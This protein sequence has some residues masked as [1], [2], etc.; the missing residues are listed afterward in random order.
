MPPSLLYLNPF[1]KVQLP[2]GNRVNVDRLDA[3][4]FVLFEPLLGQPI[5]VWLFFESP[6]KGN[7]VIVIAL[8]TIGREGTASGRAP[9][10]EWLSKNVILA[11]SSATVAGS[12]TRILL[13]QNVFS[14]A[15]ACSCNA[16]FQSSS[17]GSINH[18]S[19]R[20]PTEQKSCRLWYPWYFFGLARSEF[21]WRL[22]HRGPARPFLFLILKC[23]ES[24]SN[25]LNVITARV[26]AGK[27]GAVNSC[28]YI[29]IN[30]RPHL[31]DLNPHSYLSST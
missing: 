19:A 29:R 7:K 1:F 21:H 22:M 2:S 17:L 30:F 24:S 11:F 27:F 18:S 23:P 12:S 13:A 31:W 15:R 8:V 20:V 6:N 3:K 16:T 9:S 4:L 26:V 14:M 10:G 28:K 5:R 25:L